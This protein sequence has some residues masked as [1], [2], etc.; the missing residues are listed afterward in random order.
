MANNYG[1]N[2]PTFSE[3]LQQNQ[4]R[5]GREYKPFYSDS[6]DYNTNAPSYYD[7]LARNNKLIEILAKRIW[8][9]DEELAKRFEEW[10]K[11]LEELPEDLKNLLIE[12]MEDGT[13]DDIINQNIFNDLNN[14]I[15]KVS[16]R[17][18][19]VDDFG[20]DPTGET[21]STKSFEKAFSDGNVH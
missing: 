11:N 16:N 18:R 21:D 8:E 9:Y 6:A 19:F 7:Y 3:Y 14:K 2:F 17:F 12:W 10:D 20:G 5:Q 1:G 4:V 13:L 15:D